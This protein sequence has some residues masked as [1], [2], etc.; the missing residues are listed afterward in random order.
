[1]A[2]SKDNI[3][4]LIS[5][6]EEQGYSFVLGIIKSDKENKDNDNLEIY[7]N[8]GHEPLDK[9]LKVLKDYKKTRDAK[10]IDKKKE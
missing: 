7:T 10:V 3:N 8:T 5:M 1:M 4:E 2:G 9:L 6:I